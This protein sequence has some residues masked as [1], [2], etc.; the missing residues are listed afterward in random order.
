MIVVSFKTKKVQEEILDKA[1]EYF[2]DKIDLKKR[3]HYNLYLR[4]VKSLKR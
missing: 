1:V 2:R 3:A 4:I